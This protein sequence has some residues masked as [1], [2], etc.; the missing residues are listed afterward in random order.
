M[1]GMGSAESPSAEPPTASAPS[2]T[3]SVDTLNV[4]VRILWWQGGYRA[5]CHCLDIV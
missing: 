1:P 4:S 3:T 2:S 5:L